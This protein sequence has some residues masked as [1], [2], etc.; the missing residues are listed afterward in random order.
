[1]GKRVNICFI[2]EKRNYFALNKTSCATK[3]ASKVKV[4]FKLLDVFEDFNNFVDMN[5]SENRYIN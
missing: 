1:M 5:G 3:M 2:H 4:R